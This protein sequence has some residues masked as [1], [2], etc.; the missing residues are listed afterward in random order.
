MGMRQMRVTG[1]AHGGNFG[2]SGKYRAGKRVSQILAYPD[3][4]FAASALQ[5]K[6]LISIAGKS[7]ELV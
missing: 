2:D 5:E 6:F 3:C 7:V 4:G 1:V